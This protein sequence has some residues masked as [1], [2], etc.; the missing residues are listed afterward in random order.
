MLKYILL[1]TLLLIFTI[2]CYS[3]EAK[4][5][6]EKRE[7][8]LGNI[9]E[10]KGE[11]SFDLRFANTG[12]SPLLIRNV[13]GSCGCTTP[14][15]SRKPILPGEKSI[16]KITIDP[17]NRKGT[18][19][20]SVTITTNTSPASHVIQIKGKIIPRPKT[21]IDYYPLN[22]DGLRFKKE[23]IPLMNI[24]NSMKLNTSIGYIN[25]NTVP[26]RIERIDNLQHIKTNYSKQVIPPNEKGEL[27]IYFDAKEKNDWGFTIDTLKFSINGIHKPE[28]ILIVSSTIKEDFSLLTPEEKIKAPIAIFNHT[29]FN[30]NTAEKG[31][32]QKDNLE[33]ENKGKSVLII[34]KIICSCKDINITYLKKDIKPGEKTEI[35]IIFA[36]KNRLGLQNKYITFIT[37]DPNKPIV[38]YKITGVIQNIKR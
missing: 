27:Y 24:T 37:N 38:K 32:I 16:I 33:I 18:F 12:K 5:S 21:V 25:T 14:E 4:I 23:H 35:S 30:F 1:H 10:E 22:M 13:K 11:V 9:K 17:K 36:T 29:L 19:D 7:I 34:R 20:K 26:L 2:N 6:F 28:Y 3:Q 15:W 31:S 8:N